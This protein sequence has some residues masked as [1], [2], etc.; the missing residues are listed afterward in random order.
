LF[1]GE[2]LP[3]C[4]FFAVK[5]RRKREKVV[6][7]HPKCIKMM[8]EDVRKETLKRVAHEL[9]IAGQK[10][11]APLTEEQ[12]ASICSALGISTL[13]EGEVYGYNPSTEE[14]LTAYASF[15]GW[16]DV[17]GDFANWTGSADVP[18]CVKIYDDGA[19]YYC[20]NLGGMQG[21]YK[22]YWAIT[23]DGKAALV[24]VTF[25]YLQ[26]TVGAEDLSDGYLGN[27][28]PEYTV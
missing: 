1:R 23:K 5:I 9:A 17:N 26:Y 8:E 25:S 16:R 19:N 22:T 4:S 10:Q 12:I 7:L 2:L 14:F 28:S 27:S 18:A 13:A 3:F 15:D 20:Y 21:Q 6:S 24:E 11:K